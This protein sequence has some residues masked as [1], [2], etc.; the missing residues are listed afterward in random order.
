ME[1]N[2]PEDFSEKSLNSQKDF[3]K[4][5]LKKFL[6]EFDRFFKNAVGISGLILENYPGEISGQISKRIPKKLLLFVVIFFRNPWKKSQY[7]RMLYC[8][9]GHKTHKGN[10]SIFFSHIW[11]HEKKAEGFLYL[12]REISISFGATQIL[13][14]TSIL[15]QRW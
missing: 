9:W 6:D 15:T 3:L 14:F 8:V 2:I 7:S 12:G 13:I 10:F 5:F 4:E 11:G 1:V